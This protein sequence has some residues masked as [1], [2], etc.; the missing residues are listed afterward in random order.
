MYM[1]SSSANNISNAR[2]FNDLIRSYHPYPSQLK[3]EQCRGAIDGYPIQLYI[4]G[5]YSG[6]YTFNVDRYA[7]RTLGFEPLT[8]GEA[9]NCMAYE[10]AANTNSGA[11]AFITQGDDAATWNVAK[12]EFKY[13]YH[14]A[15]ENV[16]TAKDAE[17]GNATILADG[18]YHKELLELIKWTSD[19]E[20]SDFRRDIGMHWSL[21]H[22][23]DYFLFVYVVGLVD[24]F[25]KVS[26]EVK[27]YLIDLEA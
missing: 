9:D 25:G 17:N 23:I 4:N 27:L 21:K 15:G 18:T 26:A 7:N 24:N 12:R 20:N 5:E 14:Y 19:S 1:D 6:L 11:G 22:L 3:N 2:M 10:V 16:A 13:R 8:P